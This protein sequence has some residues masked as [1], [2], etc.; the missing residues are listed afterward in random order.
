[1]SEHD[2][3][4]PDSER[5]GVYH[6]IPSEVGREPPKEMQIFASLV[7]A[8]LDKRLGGIMKGIDDILAF[9]QEVSAI[10][11]QLA[12]QGREIQSLKAWRERVERLFP[13]AAE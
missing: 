10:K 7:G 12:E 4:P 2:T 6:E 11:T 5:T 9:A 1:M 3:L 8:E 13:G